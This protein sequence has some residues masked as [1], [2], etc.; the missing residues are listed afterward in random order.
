MNTTNEVF[1]LISKIEKKLTQKNFNIIGIEWNSESNVLI[2][3]LEDNLKSY[4]EVHIPVIFKIK[5]IPKK[6]FNIK[7]TKVPSV[8]EIKDFKKFL[9]KII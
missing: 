7:F 1:N 4:I 8:K 6:P 2:F 9:N 3:Q 5:C